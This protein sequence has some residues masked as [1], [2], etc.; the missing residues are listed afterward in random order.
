LVTLSSDKPFREGVADLTI[1]AGKISALGLIL[2]AAENVETVSGDGVVGFLR[3]PK[4]PERVVV[5]F[6]PP[7]RGRVRLYWK[8]TLPGAGPLAPSSVEGEDGGESYLAAA[9]DRG[10]EIEAKESPGLERADP[11]DLPPFLR[12]LLPE[13]AAL[14]FRVSPGSQEHVLIAESRIFPEAVAKEA[15]IERASATSIFTRD[16][17]RVDR[18]RASVK[19]KNSSLAWPLPEGATIW[20]VFVN[21]KPVKPSGDA[22]ETRIPLR[23]GLGSADLDIVV[24]RAGFKLGKRGEVELGLFT[25]PHPVLA[26]SWSLYFPDGKRYRVQGGNL[27]EVPE[28]VV[29]PALPG[30]LSMH[31]DPK[32]TAQSVPER[33][34]WALNWRAAENY[35]T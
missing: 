29:A 6:L 34:R 22:A 20:S 8:T 13:Q 18:I 10:N 19:T 28:D 25:L 12:S 4:K 7:A 35:P 32:K 24:S 15:V 21:G 9:A 23:G 3:D 11:K 30:F 17:A 31:L 1:L 14:L 27:W 26:I 5:N 16:G 2:P 33:S